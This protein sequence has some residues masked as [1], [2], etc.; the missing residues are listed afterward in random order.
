[1]LRLLTKQ[2]AKPKGRLNLTTTTMIQLSTEARAVEV[3]YHL[4]NPVRMFRLRDPDDQHRFFADV[5]QT[6]TGEFDWLP[7]GTGKLTRVRITNP[8]VFF[9]DFLLEA[10]QRVWPPMFATK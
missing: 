3:F 2:L 4:T 8:A 7:Y 10:F 5:E 6:S 1:M 9:P